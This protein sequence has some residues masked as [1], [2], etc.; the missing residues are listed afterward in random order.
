MA[1]AS[2]TVVASARRGCNHK[3]IFAREK[4]TQRRLT[5]ATTASLTVASARRGCSQEGGVRCSTS[6]TFDAHSQGPTAAVSQLM[7]ISR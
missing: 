6:R 1:A 7:T 2:L 5:K 3:W 4:N